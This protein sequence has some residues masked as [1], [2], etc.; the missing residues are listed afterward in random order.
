MRI[1]SEMIF[2]SRVTPPCSL[3]TQWWLWPRV[4]IVLL[5]LELSRQFVTVFNWPMLTRVG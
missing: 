5:R 4:I 2:E 1:I 3:A